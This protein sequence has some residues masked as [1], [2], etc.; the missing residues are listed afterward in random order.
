MAAKASDTVFG[1][2]LSVEVGPKV[3]CRGGSGRKDCVSSLRSRCESA[4][5][6]AVG[7][8]RSVA[9]LSRSGAYVSSEEARRS[10]RETCWSR[11]ASRSGR[12]EGV[13]C[14]C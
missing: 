13:L 14:Q 3:W 12:Y 5:A 9:R 11:L 8:C 1:G 2:M 10:V 4:T 6:G 7:S